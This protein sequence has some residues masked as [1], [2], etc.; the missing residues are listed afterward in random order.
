MTFVLAAAAPAPEASHGV[1][2]LFTQSFDPFS[3][4]L[5]LGSLVAVAWIVRVIL[6]IRASVIAPPATTRILADR[7]RNGDT[8]AL[9]REAEEADTFVARVVVAAL[10]TLPRGDAAVREAAEIEASLQS[11]RWFRRLEV[12][13]VIGNL[14]PL[15]GL[16]GTVWGMIVAFVALGET[17]GEAG[18]AALSLGISKALFHTLLGLVLA[19][20]CLAV[21]GV[22]RNIVDRIC[23]RAMTDAARIVEDLLATQRDK[24]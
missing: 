9:R 21:F 15:I 6:D 24:G 13:N 5:L 7:A 4:V 2:W 22:Y 20:P 11:A 18:P 8:K 3:V 16:A 19:I 14:G 10:D 12:L 17:G 23:N 1:W